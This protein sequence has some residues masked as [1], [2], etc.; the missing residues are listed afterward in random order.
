[1]NSPPP[2]AAAAVAACGRLFK[3][4]MPGWD[5]SGRAA[6][7]P[8]VRA[9]RPPPSAGDAQRAVRGC[10][11]CG[12]LRSKLVLLHMHERVAFLRGKGE[13]WSCAEGC[14]VGREQRRASCKF[15]RG[16]ERP[17]AR[18]LLSLGVTCR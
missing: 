16:P 15:P 12:G 3:G 14:S 7:P 5:A 4:A 13:A 17:A 2:A 8:A 6:R 1:M 18:H 9:L 11:S 10:S